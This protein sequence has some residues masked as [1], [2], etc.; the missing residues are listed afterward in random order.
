MYDFLVLLES[1]FARGNERWT[2]EE[3]YGRVG[4]PVQYNAVTQNIGVSA[5]GREPVYFLAPGEI[6]NKIDFVQ[7]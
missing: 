7:V 6:I 1:I 4:V 2:A 3:A 5:P